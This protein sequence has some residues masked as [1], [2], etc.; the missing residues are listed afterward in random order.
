M[1]VHHG[2]VRDGD[3]FTGDALRCILGSCLNGDTIIANI[4]MAVADPHPGAGFR[5]NPIRVRRI[6]RIQ[7]VDIVDCHI[8]ADNRINRPAR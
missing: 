4:N 2:A 7:N 8:A 1:S 6:G 3:I 5:V